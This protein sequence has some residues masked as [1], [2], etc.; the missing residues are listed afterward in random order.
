M[1][2]SGARGGASRGLLLPQGIDPKAWTS[3]STSQ[4]MLLAG[5][6]HDDGNDDDEDYDDYDDHEDAE[7]NSIVHRCA[8][9]V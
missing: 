3:N 1:C 4:Q 6:D 5:H 2:K 9:G 8:R 7:V